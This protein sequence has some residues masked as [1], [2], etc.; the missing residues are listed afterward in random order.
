M[1]QIVALL[2]LSQQAL[3]P[4]AEGVASYYTIESSSPLT[5]SGD[6]MDDDLYTCAM[7]NGEFGG[8]YL[9]VAENGRSVVC[10][11]NDRGPYVR[12][13]VIDLSEAA[14]SQ[15]QDTRHGIVRVQVY[16]IELDGLLPSFRL[17]SR[18]PAGLS[19]AS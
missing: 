8:Y 2:L 18:D 11:L 7:R 19:G 6:L 14:M 5:A 9:V 17:D 16:K 10:R 13:R 12:G 15:L 4:V 1:L 3:E